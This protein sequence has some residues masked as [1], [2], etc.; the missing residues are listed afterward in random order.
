[1][2]NVS[3]TKSVMEAKVFFEEICMDNVSGAK[4]GMETKVFLRDKYG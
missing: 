2:D 1:M 3:G 4:S